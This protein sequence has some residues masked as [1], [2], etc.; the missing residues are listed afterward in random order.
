MSSCSIGV[1]NQIRSFLSLRGAEVIAHQNAHKKK[2][3]ESNNH[4]QFIFSCHFAS[5][6][7]GNLDFL[8]S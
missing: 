8:S 4:R 2:Q 6:R 5:L 7:C 1:A 3:A